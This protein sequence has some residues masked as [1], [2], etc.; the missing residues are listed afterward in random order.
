MLSASEQHRYAR[1]MILPELGKAGQSLLQ[2]AS[3]L[4]VGA[5]GLGCP[6]LTYLNAAGV[7]KLGIVDADEVALSNLHRQVLYVQN[8]V[9]EKKVEAAKRHLLRQNPHTQIDVF[10]VVLEAENAEAVLAEY[11][12]IV[13]CTDNFPTRYLINDA[14]VLLDKIMVYGAIHKFEG[15]VAVFNYSVDEHMRSA[16]YRDLFPHPPGVHAIP[17]C[18]EIGVIGTLPGIIGTIQAN[19]VIKTIVGLEGVLFDQLFILDTKTCKSISIKYQKNPANPISGNQPS[20]FNLK[21]YMHWC[22]YVFEELPEISVETWLRMK[23]NK[24]QIIT[25]DVRELDETEGEKFVDL[26]IPLSVFEENLNTLPDDST[27]ALICHSGR[28]SKMAQSLLRGHKP[29]MR[30]YNIT[31]GFLALMEFQQSHGSEE[32]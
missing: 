27:I 13:D 2:A 24:D 21:D 19:E 4:V 32:A 1:Q 16:N 15:Q 31:G 26:K 8:D 30:T 23:S 17:N 9:G 18:A 14:C 7:G 12:I 11:D 10:P 20:I 22:A 5:G 25:V 6:V 29:D 28:R 3:V